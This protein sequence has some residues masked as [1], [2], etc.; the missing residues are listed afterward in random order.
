MHPLDKARGLDELAPIIH[1]KS[2]APAGVLR[3]LDLDVGAVLGD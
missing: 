3:T 1:E 2:P